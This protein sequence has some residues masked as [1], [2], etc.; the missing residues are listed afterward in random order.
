MFSHDIHG[1]LIEVSETRWKRVL[2]LRP[3]VYEDPPR[4]LF[5]SVSLSSLSFSLSFSL[6]YLHVQ[7]MCV[8]PLLGSSFTFVAPALVVPVAL[9]TLAALA[10]ILTDEGEDGGGGITLTRSNGNCS[11]SWSSRRF[12][13]AFTT[14]FPPV[15][16]NNESGERSAHTSRIANHARA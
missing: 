5:L 15:L 7:E 16:M 4:S 12:V 3:G 6:G 9:A 13:V 11:E 10:A 14:L 1:N 2:Q 8:V